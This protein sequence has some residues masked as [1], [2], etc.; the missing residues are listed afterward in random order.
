MKRLLL[1]LA[2]AL[3]LLAACSAPGNRLRPSPQDPS[4]PNVASIYYYLT[5]SLFHYEGDF[6][7]AGELFVR[8]A[9]QDPFSPQIKKQ[10][11]INSAYAYLNN[12]QDKDTT[13]A[14]F[15]NAREA[16]ELDFDLL[17][18]AYSVYNQA[19]DETGLE[20]V[21]NESISRYPS[22]RAYL[23][24]F[25]FEY[26]HQKSTDPQSLEQAYK[27][28]QNNADD[29]ILTARMYS[30]IN[31]KRSLTIM[32]QALKLDFK[33]ENE[34]L[35]IEI[36]LLSGADA[37][38][39][40]HF[41]TYKYP[42]DQGMMLYFL[43]TANKNKA[44]PTIMS[45]Q[46]E[47]LATADASL[48][49]E[50][51]FAAY[52]QSDSEALNKISRLLLS[53]TPEL[54]ADSKTAIFLLA[55]SLFSDS[56]PQPE[57]FAQKLYS[58]QDVDD[59]LLYRTLR[60]SLSLQDGA[61]EVNVDFYNDLVKA[62]QSKLSEGALQS[63]L[64]AIAQATDANDPAIIETRNVLCQEFVDANRGEEIDW[65]T[66]LTALHIKGLFAQKISILR[67]AID[68]FPDKPLFLNDLGYSLLDYPESYS[69]A[70]ALISRAVAL[71]PTN[72]Y[73]QDSLAW[74]YYL[75]QD[76]PNALIHISLP[77]KLE[78]P[79][80]EISYHIGVILIA[81]ANN[82]SA[83]P[84]LKTAYKDTINPDYQDKAKAALLGIGVEP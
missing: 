51:A 17:N 64:L 37:D 44:L 43:Q 74:Y 40:K 80:S 13:L 81:N 38:S 19:G 55:A 79:P 76:F 54:E 5:G 15:T 22:P 12:Q 32:E 35:F 28:A 1:L 70:G 45:L 60:Y 9:E 4:R 30:I 49:G 48:I 10:I 50:L 36:L 71:E 73:Y 8:A 11:L 29:L 82:D 16:G 41:L 3:M 78:A 53:K 65:S 34:R 72:A 52:L 84:F 20:W 14:D 39:Q 46:D 31:P 56:L 58:I 27:L 24:K 6:Q 21:I 75:V 59:M 47:I 63:Y 83:I 67:R 61:A 57:V 2:A 62:A 25:Y 77:M 23:Q 66:V 18:A 68:R 42:D 26:E 69:E 7:S 33:P